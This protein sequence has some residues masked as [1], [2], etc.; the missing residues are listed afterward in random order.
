MKNQKIVY[1]L[2]LGLLAVVCG[3]V[4]ADS[5]SKLEIARQTAKESGKTLIILK[6]SCDNDAGTDANIQVQV[7]NDNGYTDWVTLDNKG[8]DR[9]RCDEDYYYVTFPHD[10]GSVARLRTDSRG[11]APSWKLEWVAVYPANPGFPDRK[12]IWNTWLGDRKHRRVWCE[13]QDGLSSNC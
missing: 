3:T 1:T 7:N 6:T 12:R 4:G 13:Y 10:A 5:G 11:V 2:A 9:E 8:S